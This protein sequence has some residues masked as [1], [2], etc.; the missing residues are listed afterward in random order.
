MHSLFFPS[1][2]RF[3]PQRC[4]PFET[5]GA[6]APSNGFP[7]RKGM[8]VPSPLRLYSFSSFSLSPGGFL[9]CGAVFFI[10]K[11]VG[12]PLCALTSGLFLMQVFSWAVFFRFSLLEFV[13]WADGPP[14]CSRG[15]DR[16]FVFETLPVG[17]LWTFPPL[18]KNLA[19]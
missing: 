1:V 2:Q 6:I 15:V 4:V 7:L 18:L 3:F 16:A 19:T 9:S 11:G 8:V 10:S 5:S 13:S 17:F 12:R 14:C